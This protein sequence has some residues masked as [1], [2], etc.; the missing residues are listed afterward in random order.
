MQFDV[1]VVVHLNLFLSYFIIGAEKRVQNAVDFTVLD[2]R[3]VPSKLMTGHHQL[4]DVLLSTLSFLKR[5]IITE[6][7]CQDFLLGYSLLF[8][9]QFS[10]PQLC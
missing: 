10:L 9:G 1:E 4:F 3:F 5:Q 7:T 2:F 6:H 8:S